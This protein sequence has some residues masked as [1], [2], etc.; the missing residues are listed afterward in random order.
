[1]RNVKKITLL[2]LLF[3]AVGVIGAIMTFNL[4][5]EMTYAAEREVEADDISYIDIQM[6]NGS[7]NIHQAEAEQ[8]NVNLEGFVT[9]G[10]EPNFTVEVEE[11]TLEIKVKVKRRLIQINPFSVAPQ[12]NIYLPEKEYDSLTADL[13]NGAVRAAD[14]SVR[15]MQAATD[16]GS[17]TLDRIMA[18]EVEASTSNGKVELNQV[19]GEVTGKSNNGSISFTAANLDRNLDL[20]TDNGSITVKT[21]NEP[22]SAVIDAR[23]DNGSVTVFGDSDWD[24]VI[25]NGEHEIRLRTNNGRIA[26]EK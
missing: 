9:A 5:D 20:E 26:I 25:G 10:E 18:E 2:A 15:K 11:N 17:V 22:R 19:D 24:T 13:G 16:N 14:L 21:E 7:L 1:M 12:L 6:D 4:D 8:V 3:I 23:T